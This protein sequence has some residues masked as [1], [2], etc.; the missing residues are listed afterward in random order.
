MAAHDLKK[1]RTQSYRFSGYQLKRDLNNNII[2]Q[3]NPPQHF[4]IK[5]DVFGNTV[6]QYPQFRDGTK[7]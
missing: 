1:I 7:A 4:N 3:N 5:L 6:R 2:G